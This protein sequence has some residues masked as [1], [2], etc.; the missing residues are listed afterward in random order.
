M[1]TDLCCRLPPPSSEK[2]RTLS[3]KHLYDC[4]IVYDAVKIHYPF[5]ISII[6]TELGGR[7]EYRTP[8]VAKAS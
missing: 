6:F 4:L 7:G 1:V 3:L 5:T 8:R 2:K